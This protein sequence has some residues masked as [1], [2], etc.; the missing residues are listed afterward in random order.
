MGFDTEPLGYEKTV[1][2]ELQGAWKCLRD[3]LAENPG[4]DG[5]Q[6]V[7]FHVDEAMSWESVRD[8]G[9]MRG[10]LNLVRNMLQRTDAPADVIE[11]LEAVNE[12]MDETLAAL[13]A[14]EIR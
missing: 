10:R 2:S 9:Y 1:L 6:R 7:L 11:C 3:A 5:W 8:L 12:L 14:G 13:S 4:F